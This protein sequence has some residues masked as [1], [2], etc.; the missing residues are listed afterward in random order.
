MKK[1]LSITAVFILWM[2]SAFAGIITVSGYINSNTLWT[3]NNIYRLSGFV[4]VSNNATLTIQPG[5]LIQ[6]E[7]PTKGSLIITRGA[8]LIADG[9][10]CQPIVFT[11]EQPVGSRS[12][13]DWGGLI[14]LGKAPINQAGGTAIIEGGVDDGD[15]SGVY[16]GT[17]AND[18]S[19]IIRYVRIEFAGIA[20]QPNNEING[21]TM[22]GVGAGTIIDYVQVSYSGDDS[23]EWFGG[24]VNCKHLIAFR[25]TDD[26]LDTDNG[27]KG[28][29]QFVV[30]LRDPNVADVSGSNGFESDNDATGSTNTPTTRPIFTNVTDVGPLENVSDNINSNY[31]R[32]AHLRRDTECSIYN[33]LI[34]GWPTGL[35]IDGT[36][37]EANAAANDLQFQNNFLA[38]NIVD[39]E[40]N[41]GSTFN[42]QNYFN[43]QGGNQIFT[44]ASAL[45]LTD[46]FNLSDPNFL[47]QP[48]SPCLSGASFTNPRLN[49]P[50]FTQVNY[51][52]AFG[53]KNDWTKVWANWNPENTTYSGTIDYTPIITAVTTKSTCPNTGAINLTVTGGIAPFKY[54]YGGGQTTEDLS[55]IPAGTYTVTVSSGSCN[56]TKTITVASAPI[57]RPTGLTV[58]NPTA[59][60]ITLDWNTV[61]VAASYKVRYRVTGTTVW[62]NIPG[63]IT[64]SEYTFT[65]LQPNTSYDLAVATV[66]P[67]GLKSPFVQKIGS[68][69][70]SCALPSNLMATSVTMTQATISWS[71]ACNAISYNLQYRV[72]GTITYTNVNTTS[73]SATLTG[74]SPNTTYDYRVRSECGGGNNSSYTAIQ[75]FTTNARLGQSEE[76]L[77]IKGISIFPNPANN[78]VTVEITSETSKI[79]NVA[80]VNSLG[81]VVTQIDNLTVEGK[82]SRVIDL[83][84]LSSGI[85]NVTIYDGENVLSHQLVITK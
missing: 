74:L 72:T 62:T 22:G 46:P 42:I 4:Y 36:T 81:Q 25:A 84:N 51:R 28:N 38:G 24:T 12:Y 83:T 56:A 26:D 48:G 70:N 5:T 39:L 55:G 14:I 65:N 44:T 82:I 50:F 59:C 31:K 19:G 68:T 43:T 75:T 35:L 21:L 37:T 77:A 64:P 33:T 27:Y 41:T 7:K 2:T 79:V 8:K 60:T 3:S 57:P 11:S 69:N 73:A 61:P 29:V 18:N 17:D 23:Y 80:L 32:G 6:G 30:V 13:G 47:P 49:D 45:Q 76:D 15:G 58:N 63:N 71:G 85:Y 66:C 16:G 40:V 1:L 54:L 10:P 34:L 67:G 52:G 9:T 53:L 78:D 20:F